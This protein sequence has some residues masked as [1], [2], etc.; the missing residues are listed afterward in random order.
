MSLIQCLEKCLSL[1]LQFWS[2]LLL[3][4]DVVGALLVGL[5]VLDVLGLLLD[6]LELLE[7]GLEVGLGLLLLG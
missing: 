2:R 6:G 5:G 1:S 7:L 4:D 3:L